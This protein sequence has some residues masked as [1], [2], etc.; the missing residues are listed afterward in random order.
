MSTKLKIHINSNLAIPPWGFYPIEIKI[1]IYKEVRRCVTGLLA[2]T[3]TCP[4]K[5]P[6]DVSK[7]GAVKKIAA[8]DL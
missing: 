2:V 4:F 8:V 6:K 1:P 3:H 5:R 7:Y